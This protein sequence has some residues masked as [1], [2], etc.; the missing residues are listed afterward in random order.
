MGRHGGIQKK[1]IPG[2]GNA[3]GQCARYR[4]GTGECGAS[5]VFLLGSTV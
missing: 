3:R 2:K 4:D 1:N 5:T